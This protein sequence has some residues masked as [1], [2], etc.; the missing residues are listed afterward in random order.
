M[1]DFFRPSTVFFDAIINHWSVRPTLRGTGWITSKELVEDPKNIILAAVGGVVLFKHEGGG[2]YDG[3][4]FCLEG[5]RGA[6]ALALVAQGLKTVFDDSNSSLVRALAP[7]GLPGVAV[8]C[9]WAG[10]KLVDHDLFG[11]H[12][13]HYGDR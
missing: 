12:F 4:V 5:F 7:R 9:R 6:S 3:H 1:T 2:E 10:F 13:V 8:L 11:E